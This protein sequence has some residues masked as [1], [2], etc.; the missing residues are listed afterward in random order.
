MGRKDRECNQYPGVGGALPAERVCSLCKGDTFV[1]YKCEN[2]NV[3]NSS[4]LYK[5]S[6]LYLFYCTVFVRLRIV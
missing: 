1:F 5:T 6:T 3:Q 2:V 4:H